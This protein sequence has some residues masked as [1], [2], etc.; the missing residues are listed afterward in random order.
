MVGS[1]IHGVDTDRIDTQLL[2]LGDVTLANSGV[3]N[4][5][6]CL[7]RTTGL[8]VDPA[9]VET[10]VAGEESYLRSAR[11]YEQHRVVIEAAHHFP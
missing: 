2:E 7:G 5:V 3:C 4:G 8:V 10:I 1:V 6:L 9:N 11:V